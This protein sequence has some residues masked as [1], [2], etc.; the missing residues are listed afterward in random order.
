MRSPARARRS[1]ISPGSKSPRLRGHLTAESTVPR[2]AGAAA[3]DES[4]DPVAAD[5]P[6]QTFEVCACKR[7]Q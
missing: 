4:A 2:Q 7:P 5:E 3:G 6:E 1:A